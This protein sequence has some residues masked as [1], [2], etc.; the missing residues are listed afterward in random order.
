MVQVRKGLT[1]TQKFLL[2]LSFLGLLAFT[3][4]MI[5]IYQSREIEFY[6][7][8]NSRLND[9]KFSMIKLEYILDMF[10]VARHFEQEKLAFITDLSATGVHV[11]S[12]RYFKPGT[13]LHLTIEGEGHTFIAEGTV[14]WQ[15]EPTAQHAGSKEDGQGM[16]IEFTSVPKELLYLYR[17]KLAEG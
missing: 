3:D 5:F 12:Y 17:K 16:G 15:K 6:D 10:V 11:Q 4:S 13:A 2:F 7:D 9:A 8:L 14:A 1:I